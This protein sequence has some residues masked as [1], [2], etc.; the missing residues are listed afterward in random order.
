MWNIL[1]VVGCFFSVLS[2]IIAYIIARKQSTHIYRLTKIEEET[3]LIATE[4]K[5]DSYKRDVVKKFFYPNS[6]KLKCLFPVVWNDKPLPAIHAGDYHA[7]HVLQTLLGSENLDLSF[8]GRKGERKNEGSEGNSI[9]LCTPQDNPALRKHAPPL[10]IN[11]VPGQHLELTCPTFDGIELPCWFA[12]DY[13][14]HEMTRKKWVCGTNTLLPSPA[15][16]EY[17]GCYPDVEHTPKEDLQKDYAIVLRLRI[18]ETR[19]VFVMSGIHQYGTWI[20]GEFL[21]RLK[22][23]YNSKDNKSILPHVRDIFLQGSDFLAIV[24]GEFSTKEL[25]VHG[26]GIHENDAWA[27]RNGKWKRI[28]AAN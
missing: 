21:N 2:C 10:D 5:A 7:L 15:E 13:R 4:I 17:Q 27:R 28:D 14:E 12:N 11:P 26:L 25:T 24:W 16:T 8:Q 18:S 9:F 19:T 6:N 22:D 1:G 20:A 3:N 23:E